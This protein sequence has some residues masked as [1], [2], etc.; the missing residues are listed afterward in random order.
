MNEQLSKILV[1]IVGAITI[2]AIHIWEK[3]ECQVQLNF[4]GVC[5]N[6]ARILAVLDFKT[7]FVSAKYS[8]EVGSVIGSYLAMK[9]IEWSPLT[10]ETP[11]SYYQ[12]DTDINGMVQKEIFI[13]SGAL[14]K[15][16]PEMLNKQRLSFANS[17]VIV[18]CTDLHMEALLELQAIANDLMIPFWLL[19]SSIEQTN[20]FHK[21]KKLPEMISMNIA[22]LNLLTNKRAI[23]IPEIAS[24]TLEFLE[25]GNGSVALVTLGKE[26][27][28]LCIKGLKD[29]LYQ[30][31]PVL[32]NK[33]LIGAGDVFFASLLG[34]KMK[35][36]NWE[37]ALHFAAR[38]TISYIKKSGLHGPS[39]DSILNNEIFIE[40][41]V[42]EF[43]E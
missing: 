13:D 26:G 41:P 2:D 12:A 39:F 19:S 15:I 35:K 27:A 4:G 6:V 31:V 29:Y 14:S 17:S 11:L 10:F 22:E 34:S 9:K 16:S 21:F 30:K 38:S 32:S 23:T 36:T 25:K 18:S 7:R 8:G 37:T 33:I 5:N 28:I 3:N 20:T 43:Y 42:K 24:L 1:T 40:P